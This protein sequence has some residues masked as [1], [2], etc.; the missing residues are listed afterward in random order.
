MLWSSPVQDGRLAGMLC[1]WC[2]GG[3]V[4]CASSI[5][6]NSYTKDKRSMNKHLPCV[7]EYS[8]LIGVNGLQNNLD[9]VRMRPTW[10][11]ANECDELP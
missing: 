4:C 10:S 11:S 1:V 2:T 6:S 7:Q 3:G 9:C 8:T 5:R